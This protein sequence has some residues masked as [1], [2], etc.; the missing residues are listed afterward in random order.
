MNAYAY[1]SL[2]NKKNKINRIATQLE[3]LVHRF[4]LYENLY[5]KVYH[6]LIYSIV[7]SRSPLNRILFYQSE[8]CRR[9]F[10][11]SLHKMPCFC[12]VAYNHK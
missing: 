5:L 3:E 7:L 1:Q 10:A 8:T 9:T 11:P 6:R 12:L 2:N 4:Y